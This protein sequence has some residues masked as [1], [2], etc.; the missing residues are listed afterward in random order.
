MVIFSPVDRVAREVIPASTPTDRSVGASLAT[1]SSHT[2]AQN[3]RPAASLD[4]VTV[5]GS[6]PSGRA[7]DHTIAKGSDIFASVRHPSRNRNPERVYS[8]VWRHLLRDL[9]RGYFARLSKNAVN[10]ACRCR[11][12]CC[13][14][15]LE[16]SDRNPSS[17]VRFHSVNHADVCT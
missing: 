8:A 11:S 17:W 2:I 16:T 13:R 4:T 3:H 14:G 12:A 6:A 5:V 9:N 1:V 7:R 15:T 10:P